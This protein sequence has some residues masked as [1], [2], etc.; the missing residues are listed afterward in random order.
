[1][2]IEKLGVSFIFSLLS[3][4][5]SIYESLHP[6]LGQQRLANPSLVKLSTLNFT[7]VYF[8][9]WTM[10]K[11]TPISNISSIASVHE[12]WVAAQAV[13]HILDLLHSHFLPR[14]D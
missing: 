7:S 11:F 13:S 2:E 4:F 9:C 12:H 3:I 6:R 14:I 8:L 10:L 5:Y 1:M